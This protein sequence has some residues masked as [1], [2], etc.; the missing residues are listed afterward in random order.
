MHEN[1][2]MITAEH[3]AGKTPDEIQAFGMTMKKAVSIHH[4]AQIVVAGEW[5]LEELRQLPDA[6][7]VRQL[8]KL[9]GIGQWTA[10]M[11]LT[12]SMERRDVVSWGD[13]AIR[14]GIMKLYGLP[15]LS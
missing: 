5:N 8:T 7:V 15:T 13:I 12:N 6:E 2:G 10:E 11:L 14:R 3:L 4:I 1:G 9:N